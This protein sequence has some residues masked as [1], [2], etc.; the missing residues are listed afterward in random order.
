MAEAARK[1][2][3][4]PARL[5]VVADAGYS[6]G[7]QAEACEARGMAPHVPAQRAINNKG[8][9]TLFDRSQ[10]HYDQGSDTF[11]CPAGQT[12]RRKQLKKDKRCVVYTASA[13]ACGACALKSQCT[14]S[15]QRYVQVHLYDAVLERMSQRA[16][17]AVMRLRRCTVEHPFAT[18]KYRIFGHPRLLLRGVAG[19]QTEM[20]LGIMAY[21]L[22]R[23]INVLGGAKLTAALQ[24]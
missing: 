16:T 19:A 9:G 11:S 20:G 21:N 7:P 2:L 8:D 4:D 18:L 6:N 23:M 17:A 22:K 13:A 12:L 14:P 3:G 24:S 15:R 5:N 10:F 1:A